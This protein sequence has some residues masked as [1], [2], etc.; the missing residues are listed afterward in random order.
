MGSTGTYNV[1][2]PDQ[3]LLEW[4]QREQALTSGGRAQRTPV[5]ERSVVTISRQYGA[6]GHTMATLLAE[7][8]GPPWEVW[9]RHIVD[10]IATSMKVRREMVEALDEH[11]R[12]RIDQVLDSF[13]KRGPI[14]EEEYRRALIEVLLAIAHQGKKIIVGRGAN[15]V[16]EQALKVRLIASTD[17]RSHAMQFLENLSAPEAV[18]KLRRVDGERSGYIRQV[19]D[20]DVDNPFAYDIVVRMDTISFETAVATVAAAVQQHMAEM[21]LHHSQ[22]N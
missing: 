21:K 6:G 18:E 8:L 17:Y 1:E 5:P 11:S 3:R 2:E 13:R 14:G 7:R 4:F 10:A 20:A 12:N 19:F 9:D 15:F 22:T 16:V